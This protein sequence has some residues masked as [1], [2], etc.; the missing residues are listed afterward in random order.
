MTA[1]SSAYINR[2]RKAD[3]FF[4][5]DYRDA[6]I[7]K[8]AVQRALQNANK[9]FL[10]DALASSI[11][12]PKK[13]ALLERNLSDLSKGSA[14][15][16]VTGQQTGLFLGPLFNLFKVVSTVQ[17]AALLEKETG[18]RV[19]P[20]FWLQ[21]DDHDIDEIRSINIFDTH[22]IPSSIALPGDALRISIK[23]RRLGA[24]VS[25]RLAELESLYAN[26]QVALEF[27]GVL[28]KYY[29][30]ESSW[31]DAFG[32]SLAEFFAEYGLLVFDPRTDFVA[33]YAHT[34]YLRSITERTAISAALEKDSA[35]IAAAGFDLQVHIRPDS[36][37][38]FFHKNSAQGERFRLKFEDQHFTLI[39]E[40]THLGEQEILDTLNKSPLRASS[41]ALLRPIIQ[42][43]LFPVAAY[44]AG[45]GEI[46]Y[47]AQTS[48]L[49]KHFGIPMPLIVPRISARLIEP[50]IKKLLEELALE[51]CESCAGKEA[52]LERVLKN[53]G[54]VKD[55]SDP[56]K[57][58]TELLAKIERALK[59]YLTA[60]S[61]LGT[62]FEANYPETIRNLSNIVEKFSARH[63]KYLHDSNTPLKEQLERIQRSLS[64]NSQPQERFFSLCSFAARHGMN[65]LITK[66]FKGADPLNPNIQDIF[67]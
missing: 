59:E 31:S 14:A 23:Q 7:R 56:D 64:P 9:K 47:W 45:H 29:K 48:L 4:S 20:V 63:K 37:L 3:G 62:K 40:G 55:G 46:N 52:A 38:L 32:L 6:K 33:P 67:L 18:T 35:R 34:I 65:E 66:C 50:R 25:A 8:E 16:A 57:L 17:S 27:L 15:A 19:V 53:K 24:D 44:I 49:H 5:G 13:T 39:G 43:S 54:V 51:T 22:G 10:K 12:I 60:S 30:P 61:L 21:N 26:S 1:F 11:F 58:K 28:K 41:S 2:D 42:N 36:P